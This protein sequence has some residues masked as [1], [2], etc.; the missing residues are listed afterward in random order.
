[1]NLMNG[2]KK[3]MFYFNKELNT[4]F[5][6]W[7]LIDKINWRER[8][9]GNH[10]VYYEVNN[11]LKKELSIDTIIK[12][13]EYN[14][15]F[16]AILEDRIESYIKENNLEWDKFWYDSGFQFALSDDSFHYLCNF[17]LGCGKLEFERVMLNPSKVC[18]F[19]DYFEG[20]EYCFSTD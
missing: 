12:L 15:H 6:F 17:I 5:L 4:C 11:F 8:S 2:K 9:K 14:D 13:S 10:Q 18:N 16:T 1:M 3:K 19:T 7:E 20:F